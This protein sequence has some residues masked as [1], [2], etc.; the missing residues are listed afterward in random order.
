VFT[1]DLKV[2][3]EMKYRAWRWIGGGR[4]MRASFKVSEAVEA[5]LCDG[6]GAVE[7]R[8]AMAGRFRR[9]SVVL[10]FTST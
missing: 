6:T 1:M 8:L 2:H 9:M 7:R 10:E 3:I 5:G 4:D